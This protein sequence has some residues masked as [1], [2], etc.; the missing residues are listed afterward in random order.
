MKILLIFM[1]LMPVAKSDVDGTI[2]V[3]TCYRAYDYLEFRNDK[4]RMTIQIRNIW[5]MLYTFSEIK[6]WTKSGETFTF[7]VR[8]AKHCK[9]RLQ[10]IT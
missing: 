2:E 5:K 9:R 1:L 10:V 8:N 6:V 3:K 7:D 4:H